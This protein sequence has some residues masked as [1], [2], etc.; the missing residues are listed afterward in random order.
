VAKIIPRNYGQ[1]PGSVFVNLRL[2]RIF[3][4]GG[5][6]MGGM[7]GG[8]R[9]MPGGGG[10]SEQR[11]SLTFYASVRNLLNHTNPGPIVGNLT[12]PFFGQST[13]LA[14]GFG[15]SSAAGNRRLELGV[16]FSF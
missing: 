12:S 4:F 16:R 10:A 5:M 11:Y 9:G 1:S 8:G 7:G 13:S 2:S 3:G 15:P 6:R 14:G